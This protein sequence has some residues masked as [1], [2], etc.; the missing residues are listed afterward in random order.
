MRIFRLL[1]HK[2]WAKRMFM[3]F[4]SWSC[5]AWISSNV[6]AET[7]SGVKPT[8]KTAK[9]EHSNRF[10]KDIVCFMGIYLTFHRFSFQYST[11]IGLTRF[12]D[13]TVAFLPIRFFRAAQSNAVPALGK[14]TS[15]N[16]PS[17]CG[18]TSPLHL[19]PRWRCPG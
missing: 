10:R 13:E 4:S 15:K 8:S 5:C 1:C 3:A 9:A 17:P 14:Y 6:S 19:P 2:I 12:F 16:P 18:G 11:Q 7:D